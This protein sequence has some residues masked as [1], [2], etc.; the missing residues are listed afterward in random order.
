MCIGNK[1]NSPNCV[2][3]AYDLIVYLPIPHK[4]TNTFKHK[5]VKLLR[6]MSIYFVHKK[7]K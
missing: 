1:L 4:Q 5:E 7:Q 6:L 2:M 3:A